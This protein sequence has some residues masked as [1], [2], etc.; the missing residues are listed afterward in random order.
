[1]SSKAEKIGASIRNQDA[2]GQNISLNFK[3]EDSYKTIPGGI[4]S[5]FVVLCLLSY[6]AL[7]LKY[8]VNV[9]EWSLV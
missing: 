9:E 8:M 2:F 4:L 3:G 1:M 7:K 5:V 6:F